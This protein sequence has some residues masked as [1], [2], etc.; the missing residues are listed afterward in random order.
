MFKYKHMRLSTLNVCTLCKL[1]L[2]PLL[3]FVAAQA[4]AKKL[5]PTET[6]ST[7]SQSGSLIEKVAITPQIA[8]IIDDLGYS[9]ESGRLLANFPF[10]LTM[11]VI[12][13]SPHS[14]YVA[15]LA[16][17]LDQELILH[18][19]M[20]PKSVTKWEQGLSTRQS[21]TEFLAKLNNMLDDYPTITGINNHGGS[22]LTA[23]RE[24]MGWVMETLFDRKLFFVDSRT[25]SESAAIDAAKA[26]TVQHLSRDVFLDHVQNAEEIDAAFER[27]R[28]IAR[29]Y[30]HA[31]AIGHPHEVTIERLSEQMPQLIAEGFQL[32]YLSEIL[33]SNTEQTSNTR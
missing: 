7:N 15:R 21:K 17:D 11:A 23:D 12:P 32:T 6:N 25:T 33:L 9:E 19:P 5:A 28:R 2:L 1:A 30:G 18:V 13:D 24:R 4:H 10:P 31:I 26:H 20:E 27:V 29:R 3:V 16:N 8:I 22:L 14:H